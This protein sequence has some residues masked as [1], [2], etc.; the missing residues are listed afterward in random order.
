MDMDFALFRPVADN[1][2]D[3]RNVRARFYDKAVKTDKT[4]KNGLPIFKNV[5]YVEIRL[6]DNSTEVFNQPA[7]AEKIKRFPREYELYQAAKKQTATGT[8]LE[9]FAFLSAAEL[10]TCRNRGVF[11]VENLADLSAE[12]IQSLGLQNEQRLAKLFLQKARENNVIAA[13]AHK[14]EEY[15]ATIEKLMGKVKLLTQQLEKQKNR[16]KGG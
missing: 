3:E 16:K 10:E 5:T 15:K 2:N 7:S 12:K 6:K 1:L 9:Q 4:T 11:T 14:E 8:P 13:F